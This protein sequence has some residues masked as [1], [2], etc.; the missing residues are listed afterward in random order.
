MDSTPSKPAPKRPSGNIFPKVSC[1][2]HL[3]PRKR[4]GMGGKGLIF[5][6]AF[7]LCAGLIAFA[8]VLNQTGSGDPGEANQSG[9][10]SDFEMSVARQ[11]QPEISQATKLFTPTKP[12]IIVCPADTSIALPPVS[13]ME[14]ISAVPSPPPTT[15]TADTSKPSETAGSPGKSSSKSSKKT[16]SGSGSGLGKT[17]KRAKPSSPPKLLQAP[18]PIY[19][20]KAKAEKITGKTAVLIQVRSNGA[21]GATS[22]YHSSGNGELDKAAVAAARSWKFSS[23]PTLGDGETI[24]VIVHV[25][26][27]L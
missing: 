22:L 5:S 1:V 20:A 8:I 7:H 6:L 4:P 26:F 14:L 3:G 21:A 16:G 12:R 10:Y 18:P 9:A 24:P 17:A 15:E 27:S 11:V 19:P 23:S 25:T 13:P 2:P